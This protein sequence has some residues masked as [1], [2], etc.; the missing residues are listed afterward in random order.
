MGLGMSKAQRPA[1]IG[2]KQEAGRAVG[3]L[4]QSFDCNLQS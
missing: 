2:D 3:L 1:E 4:N